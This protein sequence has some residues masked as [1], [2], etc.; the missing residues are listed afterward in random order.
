MARATGDSAVRIVFLAKAP[1]PKK[2]ILTLGKVGSHPRPYLV[3]ELV[4]RP[5]NA[6]AAPVVAVIRQPKR[7][8]NILTMGEQKKIM[9]MARAATH[10]AE[11]RSTETLEVT[12]VS[13]AVAAT[14]L[15]LWPFHGDTDIQ[16]GMY[17]GVRYETGPN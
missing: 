4:W 16:S 5:M 10:A 15:L 14:S 9:P 13:N 1:P 2:P 7:S 8:V 3:K 6:T 17:T 11:K 12:V